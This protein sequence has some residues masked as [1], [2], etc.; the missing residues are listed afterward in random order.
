M[1]EREKKDQITKRGRI[2]DRKIKIYRKEKEV[3]GKKK[4]NQ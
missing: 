2:K 4:V 1:R 3:R